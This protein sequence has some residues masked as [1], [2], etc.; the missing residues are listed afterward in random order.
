MLCGCCGCCGREPHEPTIEHAPV[1][2]NSLSLG[3]AAT[4][5]DRVTDLDS[6]PASI[7]RIQAAARGKQRRHST[8]IVE[9]ALQLS[10]E[11]P[12][13]P[14]V[15]RPA[16][17]HSSTRAVLFA[18]EDSTGSVRAPAAAPA[19]SEPTAAPVLARVEEAGPSD[20]HSD[21]TA[22]ATGTAPRFQVAATAL[23]EASQG[24]AQSAREVAGT[25]RSRKREPGGASPVSVRLTAFARSFHGGSA[26]RLFKRASTG[27][28][29]AQE[30]SSHP[31]LG[32][33]SGSVMTSTSM[34]TSSEPSRTP[35]E[36][37]SS[38]KRLQANLQGVGASFS[39]SRAFRASRP[40]ARAATAPAPADDGLS[41]REP[42]QEGRRQ[43]SQHRGSVAARS[44]R[45]LVRPR[46][47]VR[48]NTDIRV[49]VLERSGGG[50]V[51]SA[52]LRSTGHGPT[53]HAF[54]EALR[55]LG[56][57][58]QAQRLA[59]L[60]RKLAMCITAGRVSPSD[61]QK[62]MNVLIYKAASRCVEKLDRM[63]I[64][65]WW[66]TG[67]RGKKGNDPNDLVH[68]DL[69]SS[70]HTLGEALVVML[71]PHLGANSISEVD[72][73]FDFVCETRHIQDFFVRPGLKSQRALIFGAMRDAC[74]L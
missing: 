17:Q 68:E 67:Q 5:A 74:G 41:A 56:G 1:R 50:K 35:R 69:I 31:S 2:I 62:K 25:V 42:P 65:H 12:S 38:F 71:Q 49:R 53:L 26:R 29:S 59:A 60:V 18:L 36:S 58:V 61:L 19:E 66:L 48:R 51:I 16:S 46:E 11:Q 32:T 63:E 3:T 27:S 73:L 52:V 45:W 33:P 40:S 57:E 13:E 20:E 34:M 4:L 64:H 39:L 22:R 55:Q 14:S 47:L 7:V 24:T 6:A 21:A 8:A 30:A 37:G 10:G 28:A 54:E 9:A 72:L 23:A 43:S 44:L 70:L 15:P